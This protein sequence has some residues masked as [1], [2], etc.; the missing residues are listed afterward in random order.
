MMRNGAAET[1]ADKELRIILSQNG[2]MI[3]DIEPTTGRYMEKTKAGKIHSILSVIDTLISPGE[4][5]CRF[6]TSIWPNAKQ[7]THGC[8]CTDALLARVSANDEAGAG[9]LSRAAF[10]ANSTA[11][12][13]VPLSTLDRRQTSTDMEKAARKRSR[14]LSAPLR[15]MQLSQVP[16]HVA[17]I[18]DPAANGYAVPQV[19]PVQASMQSAPMFVNTPGQEHAEQGATQVQQNDDQHAA[20]WRTTQARSQELKQNSERQRASLFALQ[21]GQ[22]QQESQPQHQRVQDKHMM[23]AGPL[24]QQQV[25]AH[26]PS[27]AQWT[28]PVPN[29]TA[30]N[31]TMNSSDP[32]ADIMALTNELRRRQQQ[33][34]QLQQQQQHSQMASGGPTSAPTQQTTAPAPGSRRRRSK[35]KTNCR[36]ISDFGRSMTEM[37]RSTDEIVQ[38]NMRII[39]SWQHPVQTPIPLPKADCS[40]AEMQ[41]SITEALERSQQI[42]SSW[43]RCSQDNAQSELQTEQA[44]S[45]N[46]PTPSPWVQ[47]RPETSEWDLSM[48]G[49]LDIP[50]D[51]QSTFD[52]D[53][54]RADA[55]GTS[56]FGIEMMP[57]PDALDMPLDKGSTFE[58]NESSNGAAETENFSTAIMP[59]LSMLPSG[60]GD[61][62][63]L[64]SGGAGLYPV[65][66]AP[67]AKT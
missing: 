16:G 39:S 33:Q 67:L 7:T 32:F 4:P 38:K 45:S 46:E 57:I 58:A 51:R 20:W 61:A 30:P 9:R 14:P 52:E 41:E 65:G 50:L 55:A 37:R 34:R 53:A 48:P 28:A 63:S 47:P 44:G 27:Q 15:G 26:P 12:T 25:P 24:T 17:S 8:G 59:W 64:Y 18:Y 10:A 42:G 23:M 3:N 40:L 19:A 35:P 29:D 2:M 11:R 56:D 49:A 43:Q 66:A 60:G 22:L 5:S 54:C 13:C 36:P 62:A 1:F 21:C 31:L 6:C